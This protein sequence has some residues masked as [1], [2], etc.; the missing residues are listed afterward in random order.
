MFMK[1]MLPSNLLSKQELTVTCSCWDSPLFWYELPILMCLR[2][3]S[4]SLFNLLHEVMALI[5]RTLPD[6]P[7]LK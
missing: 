6:N 4:T 2:I 7:T 3:H 1:F 5:F